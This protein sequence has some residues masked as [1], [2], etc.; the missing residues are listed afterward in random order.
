MNLIRS[1]PAC[2]QRLITGLIRT[3]SILIRNNKPI[4]C[5][6]SSLLRREA[7]TTTNSAPTA[8]IFDTETT[9]KADFKLPSYHPTQPHLVQLGMILVDTS[10][11][12]T[13]AQLSMLVKLR[14]GITIDKG[15]ESTH[16]ISSEQ[17]NRFG[18]HP[19]TAAGIFCDL[20]QQ[21][22]ILVAHNLQFDSIVMEAALHRSCSTRKNKL[23]KLM[24]ENDDKQRICTMHESTELV[25]LPGKHGNNYKWPSLSETYSF[26]TSGEELEGGHDALVDANAC[27]SIFR[28]LVENDIVQLNEVATARDD[29]NVTIIEA[30][31]EKDHATTVS[32]TSKDVVEVVT[33]VHTYE[34]DFGKYKGLQWSDPK[35]DNGYRDWIIK[36]KIWR[37]RSDLWEYLYKVELVREPPLI[38]KDWQDITNIDHRRL[39]QDQR[40]LV[41]TR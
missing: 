36:Q 4:L 20:Y 40:L 31:E 34:F 2:S 27:K 11:W 15:A 28:Y 5:S 6:C 22:D 19:D 30:S 17:C 8:L 13:K 16:G 37:D 14:E 24:D 32:T 7:S 21:S 18:V 41:S 3:R 38:M 9:S 10:N 12:I 29:D 1:F 33:E 23:S 25:K 39:L 26:I 35:V